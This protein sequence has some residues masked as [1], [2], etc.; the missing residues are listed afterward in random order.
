MINIQQATRT[1]LEFYKMGDYKQAELTC[2][3]ILDVEPDNGQILH[4]LGSIYYELGSY[5]LAIDYFKKAIVSMPNNENVFYDLGSAFQEK[6]QVGEALTYY[7]KVLQFNPDYIDAYNNIGL[8]YQDKGQ[9][10]DAIA[11]YQKALRIDANND[12]LNNNL[13]LVFQEKGNIDEAI[14]H[15]Q[16]AI[17]LNPY[18]TDAYYNLGIIFK[19]KGQIEE[20]INCYQM[21]LQLNPDN[22]DAYYNLGI[23]LHKKG[24]LEEA[25][26]SYMKG[27]ELNPSVPEVFYNLGNV[28]KDKGELTE[29]I[30]NYRHAIILK[31]DFV[32]AY[33][34]LG[35]ALIV[36]GNIGEALNA[37]ENAVAY[38]PDYVMAQWANYIWQIPIIYKDYT[39][40]QF[41]R[42][43]YYEELIKLRDTIPLGTVQ[44]IDNAA[45][46]IGSHQP[47][48]LAYQ[49]FNDREL[50][51]IYGDLVCRI[52]SLRYPEFGKRPGML[53]YLSGEPIRVGVVSGLFRD[54][55]VW[56]IPMKGWI[57]NLDRERFKLYGYYTWKVKDKE[58]EAAKKYFSRFIEDIQ[59]FD[60]LC[61][62]IRGDN[63][64]ILIYP[65]IGMDP[66]TARLAALRLCPIQCTSWG[67]PDT[68]GFPTIDYFLSSDLM[69]PS[70]ADN[71]YTEKLVRLPNLSIY[72]T[73]MDIPFAEL[74][75]DN[76]GL[77][78]GSVLYHCCQSLFKFLPQYDEVFPSIAEQVGDCQFLFTSGESSLITEQF[79]LRLTEVFNRYNLSASYHLVFLPPL[80][81]KSY[82]ALNLISDAYLESIGW[83]GCNSALE[84]LSCNLPVVTLPGRLM[85]SRD[86]FA[87]LTMMGVT[88]T[89]ASTLDEYIEI[90]VRLGIDPNWR[91]TISDRIAENKHLV[92]RDRTCIIALEDF[93][94]R[95]VKERPNSNLYS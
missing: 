71:H 52:M 66:I 94:E 4:L 25:I 56:R 46:A 23:A 32:D 33:Y 74:N 90:A 16:K 29:A 37:Y 64:H 31:S 45:R 63:L 77:R 62:T 39:S 83:S 26:K 51:K 61:Q 91:K 65:E 2:K 69:E 14:K 89:V 35:N 43:R 44:D 86:S 76:L 22:A 6:K 27:I 70:D 24:L 3:G 60:E 47:F 9:L 41:C 79:R 5:D 8:I 48:L 15:Y 92:Y 11:I 85:R 80:D 7:R 38:K 75:R 40:I 82:Q 57:Q 30:E 19:E 68:S 28:L 12:I 53:P 87:I 95:V 59:S 34:N 58:S 84:A 21:V 18:Y 50:Q 67:H 73:P 42:N 93:I 17:Q 13:G 72:Y 88:E 55:A 20:A 81:R 49:G 54:H 36:E 1:A 78:A 10:D